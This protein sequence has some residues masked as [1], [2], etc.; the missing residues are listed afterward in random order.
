ME[1]ETEHSDLSKSRMNRDKKDVAS[2]A[3][4]FDDRNPFKCNNVSLRCLS[5]GKTAV[6][7][8]GINCDEVEKW[9]Q[10]SM[11]QWTV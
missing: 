10:L 8:D 3:A 1:W 5:T 7:G 2:L 9:G 11:Q 4:W 6:D